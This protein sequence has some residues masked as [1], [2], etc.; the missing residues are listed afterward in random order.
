MPA[1][2]LTVAYDGAGFAGWAAQPGQRTIEGELSAALER[3]LGQPIELTVAGRTDAGVHALGQVASLYVEGEPPVTLTRSLNALTPPAISVLDASEAADGFDARHDA[4]AR[5]YCYRLLTRAAP[6]PFEHGRSLWWPHKLD[7]DALAACAE[8]LEG[9]HDFTAFTPTVTEHVHFHREV[10]SAA[11]RGVDRAAETRAPWER[12]EGAEDELATPAAAGLE[13]WIEADAFMR[14]MVRVLVGTMLEVGGG[15][16]SL[17]DF[18][19]LLTG[20][21]RERA[22]ETAPPHGLYLAS[23]SYDD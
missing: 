19:S 3:V 6:D 15:R 13:F 22:G 21:P 11:W 5:T 4:H 2:R 14:H 12:A 18:S 23:V 20:A 8:A 10:L 7:R 16:R 9:V 17:E 1:L